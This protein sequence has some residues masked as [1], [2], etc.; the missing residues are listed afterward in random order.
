MSKNP[1]FKNLDETLNYLRAELSR[2]EKEVNSRLDKMDTTINK[3]S[4]SL[5]ETRSS[6]TAVMLRLDFAIN[7]VE[8]VKKPATRSKKVEEETPNGEQKELPDGE[9][10]KLK[11]YRDVK[12]CF[13]GNYKDNA[14]IFDKWLT[15]EIKKKIEDERKPKD[16]KQ[17]VAFYYEYMNTHHHGILETL[18]AGVMPN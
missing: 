12:S 17:R 5:E 16:E 8:P 4:L 11:K 15:A 13:N 18:K 2:F 9:E 6:I 1:D 7:S 14:N 3:N 10:S